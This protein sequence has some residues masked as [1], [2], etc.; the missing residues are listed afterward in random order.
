MAGLIRDEQLHGGVSQHFLG[1]E[2]PKHVTFLA[3]KFE[4]SVILEPAGP[5]ED[6]RRHMLRYLL[7]SVSILLPTEAGADDFPKSGEAEYLLRLR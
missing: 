3:S 7:M 5:R 2:G 1:P 4:G 6:T